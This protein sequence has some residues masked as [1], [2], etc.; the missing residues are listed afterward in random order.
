MYHPEAIREAN[1]DNEVQVYAP[2]VEVRMGSLLY[3]QLKPRLGAEDVGVRASGALTSDVKRCA[4]CLVI[5]MSIN[6]S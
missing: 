3:S 1:I 6:L 5:R 4:H 2:D